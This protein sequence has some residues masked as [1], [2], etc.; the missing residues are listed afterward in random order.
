VNP[1][2]DDDAFAELWADRLTLGPEAGTGRPT[3]QHLQS[4]AECRARDAAFGAWLEDLR[5]DASAEA[6]K[7]VSP[8][9]LAGQQAQILRRLE[10][11]DHPGRVIVFPKATPTVATAPAGPQRW[12]AAAAA[13]G[14]LVGLGLG[15]L[16]EFG[17]ATTRSD[18]RPQPQ[19]QVVARSGPGAQDG[20]LMGVQPASQLSD[21]SVLYDYEPAAGPVHVPESLQYLNAV[22][23]GAR[24]FEP[25]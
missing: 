1:H 6:D 15:Q 11:L 5:T 17:G 21:E 23:P 16:F 19:Q 25:R 14:L 10:A 9:R 13:A 18:A 4:C 2:L 12:I 20:A 8:D 24:D 3:G 22:T 7:A